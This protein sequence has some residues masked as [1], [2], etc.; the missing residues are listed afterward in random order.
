MGL[1]GA[2]G[3]VVLTVWAAS[4]AAADARMT[5]RLGPRT[6]Y[7]RD[8]TQATLRV[9]TTN[10]SPDA[11]AMHV[12]CAIADQW[13]GRQTVPST[14]G[15]AVAQFRFSPMALK[16]GT[17]A[18]RVMV[19]PA[20]GEAVST[21]LNLA[22][23]PALRRDLYPVHAWGGLAGSEDWWRFSG[24][25]GLN[26]LGA[27]VIGDT[28]LDRMGRDGVTYTWD[29]FVGDGNYAP[30]NR[31]AI[32]ARTL[33]RAQQ[34]A[35]F[36]NWTHTLLN[37][38]RGPGKLPDEA[39]RRAWFD[40]WAEGE[41]GFPGSA[42]GFAIGTSHNPD[43]C[44]FAA[45]EAPGPDGVYRDTPRSFKW[46][47]WWYDRGASNWRI[48]ALATETIH[49]AR[50]DVR[51]WTAPVGGT[52]QIADL[53]AAATWSYALRP[54]ELFGELESSRAYARDAGK[55]FLA[56]LGMYYGNFPWLVATLPGGTTNRLA[57]T[58]D[59]MIQQS[60]IASAIVPS[61]GL[62]YWFLDAWYYALQGKPIAWCPAEIPPYCP[63]G[64]DAALGAAIKN[65]LRPLGTMLRGAPNASRAV[66]LLLPES[67][68]WLNAGSGW[69]W[70]VVHYANAW[71]AWLGG[72]GIPY[73]VVTDSTLKPGALGRYKA[74]VFP[75]ADNVSEAV[76]REVTAAGNGGARIILDIYGRQDYP[77]MERWPQEYFYRMPETNRY[78]A[79]EQDT[80]RR[81]AALRVALEP[82]LEAFAEGDRGPLFTGVRTSG[83]ALY[84]TVVNN[85][86]QAGPYTQWT[87]RPSFLPY[88][89]EQGATVSI[90]APADSVVYEF[91]ES[92][93]LA[94]EYR[95]GRLLVHF[96]LPPHAGRVLCVY[97]RPFRKV[98]V[99]LSSRSFERGTPG[100]VTVE[101]R[102]GWRHCAAGRQLVD[103][104][105]LDPHG[106]LHDESG[107]YAAVDGRVT[108]PFRPARNDAPGMWRLDVR[109]RT[110]GLSATMSV[111]VLE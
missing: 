7:Y 43:F 59:D 10:A 63:P 73:D 79:L 13:T 61:D 17:Y 65:D 85:C 83:G 92:R 27:F 12:D 78:A 81:L 3:V 49:R 55:P 33:A 26:G 24:T 16:C 42:D 30:T 70:G 11:G 101:V 18:C 21:N 56:T 110:S 109:E 39:Q 80:R 29:W 107:I 91:T 52:G 68:L 96:Q 106:V 93:Q 4:G 25:L 20:S 99:S 31:A 8:E 22:I 15:V 6:T 90:K 38:E 98:T 57:P 89:M 48:N 102:D 45:D 75:M 51:T 64:S 47:K 104:R 46:L 60:W 36:P 84:V 41:P 5:V 37:C 111:R 105:V 14:G 62:I 72:M 69:G 28:E 67:T 95:D 44:R 82:E 108:L 74:I 86:R 100:T 71:K 9:T 1:T 54:E 35:S 32:A 76:C 103:V 88:G 53:D 66:A 34:L 2:W 23:A 97:P 94:T 87:G 19:T 77:N 40:A 58:P 50:P